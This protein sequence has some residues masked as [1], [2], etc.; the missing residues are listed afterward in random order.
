M[1]SIQDVPRVQ[2]P[3]YWPRRRLNCY[4]NVYLLFLCSGLKTYCQMNDDSLN[5]NVE[6]KLAARAGSEIRNIP[7][8]FGHA[9]VKVNVQGKLGPVNRLLYGVTLPSVLNAPNAAALF[10]PFLEG[11]SVRL[12]PYPAK[13][14]S[15]QPVMKFLEETKP[16]WIFAWV[17]HSSVP[18][19]TYYRSE[20]DNNLPNGKS[21]KDVANYVRWV[22]K[23]PHPGYPEGYNILHW[24]IWNEPEHNP[25]VTGFEPEHY[26]QYVL[27]CAKRVKEVDPRVTI[28]AFLPTR[29]S[30]MKDGTSLRG[31]EINEYSDQSEVPKNWADIFMETVIEKGAAEI[32]FIDNHQ[33][34]GLWWNVVDEYGSY[35][36][37]VAVSELIVSMFRE[38]TVNRIARYG[39]YKV[40][41]SE[42]NIHPPIPKNWKEMPLE[43]KETTYDLGAALYA[44]TSLL[45]YM[46]DGSYFAT[47]FHR[48]DR[49]KDLG[50]CGLV[51][52]SNDGSPAKTSATYNTFYL[53]GTYFKGERIE[54]QVLSDS[55][56]MFI[57][58]PVRVD[59]KTTFDYVVAGAAIEGKQL[60]LMVV[61]R[62]P[63]RPL[64][65]AVEI[66]AW[67]EWKS[68]NALSARRASLIGNQAESLETEIEIKDFTF[69]K[70]LD[71]ESTRYVDLPAHS[72]NA[73]LIGGV[74]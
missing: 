23:T 10:K 22:N 21:P 26:A 30:R 15:W 11:A 73:I 70:S 46:K 25:P 74:Q 44:A 69:E 9:F 37:R 8:K 59:W 29:R 42:W 53:F 24:E 38:S 64:R 1:H 39:K 52:V 16:A 68:A 17:P 18:K 13:E 72:V 28:G 45:G 41:N 67:P 36:P 49:Q 33:Y 58:K 3:N 48:A 62:D 4:I 61:N 34:N 55:F 65:L 35:L 19:G 31:A 56:R 32:D 43:A 71:R 47:Q 63:E 60:C 6:T 14:E 2:R 20:T 57:E 50:M 51:E 66:D 27:D 7:R 54:T 5:P 40:I 12:W